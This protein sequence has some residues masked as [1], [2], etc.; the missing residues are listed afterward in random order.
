MH[1]TYDFSNLEV[2]TLGTH[3]SLEFVFA[4]FD[5]IIVIIDLELVYQE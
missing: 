4:F 1:V 3:Y 5:P 2:K